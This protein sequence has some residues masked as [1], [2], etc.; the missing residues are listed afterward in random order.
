[1]EQLRLRIHEL[2]RPYGDRSVARYEAYLSRKDNPNQGDRARHGEWVM[3][4]F[5]D[6]DKAVVA[7]GMYHYGCPHGEWMWFYGEVLGDIFTART[8]IAKAKFL[9]GTPDGEME[10]YHLLEPVGDGLAWGT[11]ALKASFNYGR[12]AKEWVGTDPFG[13]V[14]W[15]GDYTRDSE[16]E[17]AFTE[18]AKVL[19]QANVDLRSMDAVSQIGWVKEL[20]LPVLSFGAYAMVCWMLVRPMRPQLPPQPQRR[21]A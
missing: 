15:R 12:T 7:R 13:K 5:H 10:L 11:L 16:E 6:G 20:H 4:I 1:M 8:L 19:T 9:R 14:V 21:P 3:R 2:N 17:D 18:N